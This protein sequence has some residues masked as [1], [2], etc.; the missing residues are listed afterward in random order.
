MGLEQRFFARFLPERGQELEARLFQGLTLLAGLLSFLVVLP[1]NY[2]QK[3]FPLVNVLVAVLGLASFAIFWA[4]RRGHPL[5]GVYFVLL[6]G[7][8]DVIWFGNAGSEGS[9]GMFFL[10]ASVYLVI[11]FTGWR[12]AFMLMLFLV[13][14]SGL[15]LAERAWPDLVTRF[16]DADSRFIDLLGS[17]LVC[18][19]VIVLV[20]WIVLGSYHRERERLAESAAALR[21][22]EL[23]L[24]RAQEAGQVG[25]FSWDITRDAWISTPVLDRILGLPTDFQYNLASW[26]ALI[27]PDFQEPMAQYVEGLL[28]HRAS[29]D[30]EYPIIRPVDGEERWLYGRAEFEFDPFS[31]PLRMVGTIQDITEAKRAEDMRRNLENQVHRA[32][33]M[34]SLGSLAG[35]VAHDMNNVLGAILAMSSAH[36]SREPQDSPGWKAMDTIVRACLRGRTLVQGLLNFTRQELAEARP[37][38]L[39]MLVEDQARLLEHTTLGRV[40]VETRCEDGLPAIRGDASALSHALMNL[41]VN[42]VDAMPGGGTL[43]LAAV[44]L[45]PG[46][47]EL[48]VQDTGCGMSP[49]VLARAMDPFFTTKPHGKGT[50]LGLALVYA[51]V[52]AHGGDIDMM[53]QPGVGTTV[54]LRFPALPEPLPTPEPPSPLDTTERRSLHILIVDDDALIRESLR[55]LLELSGHAVVEAECGEEALELIPREPALDGVVLDLNMPGLGGDGTLPRLRKLR[56]ELPV[57]IATG[58][59]DQQALDLVASHPRVAILPKPFSLSELREALQAW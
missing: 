11:F 1:L 17:F 32:Q 54:R 45:P 16:P 44:S 34:E 58:R 5:R 4:A 26:N 55:A 38:D 14:G 18:N 49:D 27:R 57:L 20:L 21:D 7:L 8:L 23:Q 37:L 59:A 47:V 40:R 35:G 48:K 50:G 13:N 36:Q 53:S 43:T 2:F 46:E 51:T 30:Q 24:L 39:R 41:C 28:A 3:L 15:Y 29:F 19:L 33:K 25:T 31:R 22:R 56:P 42:A 6:L 9:I 10:S 12:R 52:K